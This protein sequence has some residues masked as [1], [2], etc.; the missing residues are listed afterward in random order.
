VKRRTTV[1]KA[2]PHN[3]VGVIDGVEVSAGELFSVRGEHGQFSFRYVY[4]PDGSWTAW[5]P[6]NSAG[7]QN[8]QWRSFSP[9]QV[10]PPKRKRQRKAA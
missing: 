4:E 2:L 9:E 7:S 1:T 3:P 6:V 5:G 10:K 8:A